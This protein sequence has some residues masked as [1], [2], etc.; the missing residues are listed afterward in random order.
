M[1]SKPQASIQDRL[2]RFHDCPC[3]RGI[4][5][6][7]A[8]LDPGTPHAPLKPRLSTTKPDCRGLNSGYSMVPCS[9]H[10]AMAIVS[11][12]SIILQDISK[13]VKASLKGVPAGAQAAGNRCNKDQSMMFVVSQTCG[14]TVTAKRA[15]IHVPTLWCLLFASP[16]T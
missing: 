4:R 5:P 10:T 6:P 8:H 7:P 9:E 1:G 15:C 12:A 3:G 2:A 13:H 11:Y 16:S 14:P